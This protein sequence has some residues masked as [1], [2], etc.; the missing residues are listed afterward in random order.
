MVWLSAGKIVDPLLERLAG[1]SNVCK[2]P[3][4]PVLEMDDR[5]VETTSSSSSD[6]EDNSGDVE[7]CR[8]SNTELWL[9]EELL[10]LASLFIIPGGT[11][12]QTNVVLI[13]FAITSLSEDEEDAA[14]LCPNSLFK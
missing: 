9:D 6:W 8:E 13:L 11:G 10:S 2:F 5:G 4:E 1:M 14:P 7:D 3:D 12:V